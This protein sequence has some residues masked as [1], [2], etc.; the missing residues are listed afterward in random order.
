MKNKTEKIVLAGLF[1]AISSIL[2]LLFH[3]IAVGGNLLGQLI[4]PMHFPVLIAGI[5]LGWK[6]GLAVG[7]I[8]PLL[9][10]VLFGTPPLYPIALAM[11]LEIGTY[12]CIIGIISQYAHPFSRR[13]INIYFS[14]FI[15]MIAGRI[16][17]GIFMATVMSIAG[18]S[19]GLAL[20]INAVVIKTLPGIILQFL[21]VPAAVMLI[22]QKKQSG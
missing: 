16:V 6:Y 10:S 12:G 3:G 21:I 4:S 7:I 22:E 19:Y 2:P 20:F 9:N 13:I 8:S 14:L 17:Y 15:A 5:I 11:A 1:I 18:N